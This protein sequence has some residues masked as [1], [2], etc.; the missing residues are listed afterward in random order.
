M[1]EKVQEDFQVVFQCIK[2]IRKMS[3]ELGT[4]A[5]SQGLRQKLDKELNSAETITNSMIVDISRI[6]NKPK[7]VKLRTQLNKTR[8][9][10]EELRKAVEK[11]K[12]LNS[13]SQTSPYLSRDSDAGGNGWNKSDVGRSVEQT[14]EFQS[15]HGNEKVAKEQEAA[16]LQIQKDTEQVAEIFQDLQELVEDQGIAVDTLEENC[17]Q[18]AANVK[19]GAKELDKAAGYQKAKR[20]KICMLLLSMLVLGGLIAAILATNS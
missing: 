14:I 10:I 1:A 9:K 20:K 18:T 6:D 15:F 16:I 4:S 19:L 17:G 5:D 7:R 3:T 13:V 2:K 12:R 11:E 8:I